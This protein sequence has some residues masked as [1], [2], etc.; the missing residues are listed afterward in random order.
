MPMP[1]WKKADEVCKKLDQLL[2]YPHRRA[3]SGEELHALNQAR[4]V[5]VELGTREWDKE[6][7]KPNA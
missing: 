7:D 2:Q 5:L 4:R 1:T 3:L 6:K